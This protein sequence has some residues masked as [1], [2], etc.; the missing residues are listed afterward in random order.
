MTQLDIDQFLT[1]AQIGAALF[2][3]AVSIYF[4]FLK[5]PF[6]KSTSKK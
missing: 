2:A 5:I 1:R 3:I 6:K 4:Y